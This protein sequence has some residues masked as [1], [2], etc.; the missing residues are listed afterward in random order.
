MPTTSDPKSK[1]E[2][3]DAADISKSEL[4]KF[5]LSHKPDK[6]WKQLWNQIDYYQTDAKKH[7]LP[8]G[9]SFPN[10]I[11][12]KWIR[13]KYP[14][15]FFLRSFPKDELTGYLDHGSPEIDIPPLDELPWAYRLCC[16]ENLKLKDRNRK[17]QEANDLM[18]QEAKEKRGRPRKT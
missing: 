10:E 16:I 1:R 7:R 18:E 5:I 9:D 15:L 14:D 4:I 6:A 3:S 13:A 2:W 12:A 11:A 8:P 17:L